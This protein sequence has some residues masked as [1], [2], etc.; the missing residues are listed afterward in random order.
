MWVLPRPTGQVEPVARHTEEMVGL[1]LRAQCT[2]CTTGRELVLHERDDLL[3]AARRDRAA[4]TG[5]G[6]DY[7]ACRPNVECAAARVPT[8]AVPP[9]RRSAPH[10][11]R[12]DLVSSRPAGLITQPDLG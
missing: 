12:C 9:S 3:R 1:R 2:T 6:K 7:M 10:S 5:L 4:S 8:H 11:R